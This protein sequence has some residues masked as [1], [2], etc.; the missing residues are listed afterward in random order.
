MQDRL[1]IEACQL[2][3][4]FYLYQDN[5]HNPHIE[6]MN[7]DHGMYSARPHETWSISRH[8]EQLHSFRVDEELDM[9]LV[10]TV[11]ERNGHPQWEERVQFL[12][13]DFRMKRWFFCRR[14]VTT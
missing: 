13:G 2:G 12:R 7:P 6:G 5:E 11:A 14:S 10:A 9:D 8:W 4:S 3:I 1:I